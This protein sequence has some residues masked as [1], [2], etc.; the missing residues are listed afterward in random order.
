MED[1]PVRR[2]YCSVCGAYT[3]G[4]QWRNRDTGHGLCEE[5]PD[6]LR[7][8]GRDDAEIKRLYGVEGVH[9]KIAEEV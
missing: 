7:K 8:C 3:T 9:F 4:R 5:C 1:L 2:M 6:Y